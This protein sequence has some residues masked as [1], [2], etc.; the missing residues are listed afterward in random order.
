MGSWTFRN[1]LWALVSPPVENLKIEWIVPFSYLIAGAFRLYDMDN[2]GYISRNELAILIDAIYKMAGSFMQD[3]S[4]QRLDTLF[5][6]MDIV[7]SY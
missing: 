4:K 3:T 6:A 7:C 2:D 1:L 5:E